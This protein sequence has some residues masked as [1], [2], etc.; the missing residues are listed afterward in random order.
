MLVWLLHVG[1]TV[2]ARGDKCMSLKT[3]S[4]CGRQRRSIE[5]EDDMIR[6][7]DCMKIENLFYWTSPAIFS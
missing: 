3:L 7:K 6:V 2:V 4:A 1:A 5:Q